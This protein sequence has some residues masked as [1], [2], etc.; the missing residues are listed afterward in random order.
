MIHKLELN[1]TWTSRRGSWSQ[2][3]SRISFWITQIVDYFANNVTFKMMR[4]VNSYSILIFFRIMVTEDHYQPH[5]YDNSDRRDTCV[6]PVLFKFPTRCHHPMKKAPLSTFIHFVFVVDLLQLPDKDTSFS[7]KSHWREVLWKSI[8]G[9]QTRIASPLCAGKRRQ[10]VWK[11]F[12]R[13][14]KP[15][16]PFTKLTKELFSALLISSV[17]LS[18]IL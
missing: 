15:R 3:S 5:I 4:L 6:I 8:R 17:R 18:F 14:A 7:S 13:V 10:K 1:V 9:Q 12:F 2:W 16:S 11:M